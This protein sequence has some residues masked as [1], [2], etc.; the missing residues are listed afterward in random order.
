MQIARESAGFQNKIHEQIGRIG[1]V[2]SYVLPGVEIRENGIHGLHARHGLY[3]HVL[4][5]T[6]TGIIDFHHDFAGYSQI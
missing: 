1:T 2:H 6:L 5:G 4:A 3:S